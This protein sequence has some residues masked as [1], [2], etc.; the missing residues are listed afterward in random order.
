MK[1][2]KLH[3]KFTKYLGDF[4]LIFL[5]WFALLFLRGTRVNSRLDVGGLRME[6]GYIRNVL[7]PKYI[8][9]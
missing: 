7:L 1:K 3:D 6:L 8:I 9:I 2:I 5:S 4:Y